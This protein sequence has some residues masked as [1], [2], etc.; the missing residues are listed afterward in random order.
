MTKF[1]F[2]LFFLF[3]TQFLFAQK[4]GAFKDFH[5]DGQLKIEGQYKNKQRIGEWKSYHPNGQLSSAFSYTKGKRNE[6]YTSYFENGIVSRKTRKIDNDYVTKAYYKSGT[7]FYEQIFGDGF[8][9]EYLEDGGLKIASN[10]VDGELNDVWKQ[11]YDTGELEWTLDYKDG[12][13]EGVYRNYYKSGQLKLEGEMRKDQKDGEEKRYLENGQLEWM[14]RYDDD[15]FDKYWVQHDTLGNVITKIKFDN[16]TIENSEIDLELL[17]TRVPEGVIERV[18]IYPGCELKLSNK[19]RQKCMSN[20]I[21]KLIAKKFNKNAV[22][23]LGLVGSQRIYVI[24]KIGT[25]GEVSCIRA[26]APHPALEA[27]AIRVI[28]L[29]PK[30]QPGIQRGETVVVPYSLPI[31]FNL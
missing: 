4:D 22:F 28:T 17:T 24:F 18:P 25:D 6:E 12:Y 10:Y 1:Y 29:L 14:G 26:K 2:F 7:L 27:E 21:S 5:E 16:G 9:R 19:D 31:V 8:Y 20:E 30:I 11:F 13:R 15:K 3:G 23:G